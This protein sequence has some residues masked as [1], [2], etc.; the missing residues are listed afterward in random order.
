MKRK[1]PVERYCPFC[2]A[3]VLSTYPLDLHADMQAHLTR[4]PSAPPITRTT[5]PNQQTASIQPQKE[6]S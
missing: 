5:H 2:H 1:P 4:C 6:S 3:L